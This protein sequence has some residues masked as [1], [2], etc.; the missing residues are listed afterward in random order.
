[1][2][3]IRAFGKFLQS[4]G[5]STLKMH[6]DYRDS[7]VRD[8]FI[9]AHE[10]ENRHCTIDANVQDKLYKSIFSTLAARQTAIPHCADSAERHQVRRAIAQEDEVTN[11]G[12]KRSS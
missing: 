7:D 4:N 3:L 9:G 1:M 5:H 2:L 8:G 11:F 6:S 10:D 12:Q